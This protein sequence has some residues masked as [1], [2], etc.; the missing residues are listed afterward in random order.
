MAKVTLSRK[1]A[2]FISPW[3]YDHTKQ[4]NSVTGGESMTVPNMA[5]TI[6]EIMIRFTRGVPPQV[7][8]GSYNEDFETPDLDSMDLVEKQQYAEAALER[9]QSLKAEREAKMKQPEP[10][11]AAS[12]P[13]SESLSDADNTE[14]NE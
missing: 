14:K 10:A 13:R 6:K 1:K 4:V 5:M 2:R 7:R 11:P 12:G 8:E 3:S 9:L